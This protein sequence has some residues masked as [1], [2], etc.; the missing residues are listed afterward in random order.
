VVEFM[1]RFSLPSG[2][3]LVAVAGLGLASVLMV[4]PK[5]SL[6][7]PFTATPYCYS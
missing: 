7:L 3:V 2:R 6:S 1:E 5:L 4:R